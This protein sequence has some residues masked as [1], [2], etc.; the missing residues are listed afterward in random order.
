MQ[1]QLYKPS[2]L[3][4]TIVTV[5]TVT[6]QVAAA[7]TRVLASSQAA[8]GDQCTDSRHSPASRHPPA[9]SAIYYPADAPR[10]ALRTHSQ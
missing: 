10:P 7:G 6:V 8:V 3:C 4:V 1:L 5:H 9:P 2:C